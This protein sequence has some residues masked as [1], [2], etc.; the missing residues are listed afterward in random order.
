MNTNKISNINNIKFIILF[1]FKIISSQ[2]WIY[3]NDLS[4][5]PNCS[6]ERSYII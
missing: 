5:E 3:T 1:V 6:Y 4:Y 2:N